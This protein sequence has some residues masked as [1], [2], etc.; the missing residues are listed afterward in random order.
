VSAPHQLIL[1][2]A[3]PRRAALLREA[4]YTFTTQPA[5]FDEAAHFG[6]LPPIPLA[7]FLAKAKAE[8]IASSFE[9]K[10]T[11]AADTVVAFGDQPLGSPA[12]EAEA[13]Q[14]IDLLTGTTHIVITGVAVRC[15]ARDIDLDCT[16]LSAVRMKNLTPAELES[17]LASG[18]WKGKAGGYGIQ[19]PDP[20]VT[21]VAGSVSNVVGLPMEQTRLLLQ[22]SGIVPQVP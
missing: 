20:I 12:F 18:R 5:H 1:A 17:Y 11:L 6:R 9:E 7:T 16:V 22:K 21:C 4:G 13:R 19:D 8:Q 10:V 2:S 15:P 14:M 3:S